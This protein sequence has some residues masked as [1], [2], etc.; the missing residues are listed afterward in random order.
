MLSSPGSLRFFKAWPAWLLGGGPTLGPDRAD[1]HS[2]AAGEPLQS[3]RLRPGGFR[4]LLKP[5]MEN[6]V[7]PPLAETEGAVGA[8]QVQGLDITHSTIGRCR[9]ILCACLHDGT[10]SKTEHSWPTSPQKSSLID[11]VVHLHEE[12][13]VWVY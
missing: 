7:S 5:Q 9:N 6:R 1:Q 13:P 2:R 4:F 10:A 12:Q 8:K 3:H 11:D